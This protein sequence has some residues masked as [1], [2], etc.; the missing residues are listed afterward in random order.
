MVE[1]Q[2]F[3]LFPWDP[4]AGRRM[5]QVLARGADRSL[6][7]LLGLQRCAELYATIDSGL[8]AGAFAEQ[9]LTCLGIAWNVTD[10]ERDRVPREGAV[11]VVANHPFGGVEGL[12]LI[13]LLRR[14]RPDVKVLANPVLTRFPELREVVIP[15]DPYGTRQGRQHNV[16]ALRA[17]HRWLAGGGM[18]VV[19]PAGEVAH[20]HLRCGEVIDPQWQIGVGHLVRRSGAAVLPVFFPGQNGPAFQTA[21]LLHP[22]L[23]TA[24]LA[25]QLL[26]KRDTCLRMRIGEAIPAKRLKMFATD[27]ELVDYLRLRT[28]LLGQQIAIKAFP[29]LGSQSDGQ[30]TL[31]VAVAPELLA[32]EIDRLPADALLHAHGVYQVWCV[33]AA[34]APQVLRE[35]GRLRELTFRG[36]GEGTGRSV[37]LDGFDEHYLHLFAWNTER[38]EVVGAYRIGATDEIL[39]QHGLAGL[40]TSTL[41]RYRPRLFTEIGPALE[42]GRSFVRPEYQ[43]SFAPLLLLW[44]GIGSFLV[45]NPRYRILFGP[46]S[47]SREYSDFARQL[48]TNSLTE[49]SLAVDLAR[50]VAPRLPVSTRLPR[51]KGCPRTLAA[52]FTSNVDTVH[53]LIAEIETEQKGLPVLLRHYLNLGGKILAFNLDPD[54]SAVIDGLILVDMDQTEP[55]TLERYLGREGAAFFR[56]H[57]VVSCT[58]TAA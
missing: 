26:N 12:A 52:T 32:E 25:R 13:A 22:R 15:L 29:A 24:L 1:A 47:I 6:S 8:D 44:Q 20:F 58:R 43:K 55:R 54:F 33:R 18:L 42:L 49:Q 16:A 56:A 36:H 23:R 38:Q 19:F 30:E 51:V 53:T 35:I 50:F 21:G 40:Y 37:D 57:R 31:A 11:V 28:C 2:P 45:H 7:S 34:Q 14:V 27:R 41:F 46:V 4:P 17:G 39:H 9:A 10:G 3:R 48:M 5:P